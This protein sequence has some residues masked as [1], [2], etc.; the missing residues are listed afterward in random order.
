M[1][2]NKILIAIKNFSQRFD[3][4]DQKL[5]AMNNNLKSYENKLDKHM[6]LTEKKFTSI[7]GYV[8]EKFDSLKK[9]HE[10]NITGVPLLKD[11]RELNDFYTSLASCLGY[12][13]DEPN[14][15][16]EVKLFK[17]VTGDNMHRIIIRFANIFQKDQ[18]LHRYFAVSK[19]ITQK[20][21]GYKENKRIYI[22]QNLVTSKYKLFRLGLY[23][24][25]TGALKQVRIFDYGMIGIQFNDSPR[26]IMM[27]DEEQLK[28]LCSQKARSGKQNAGSGAV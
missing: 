5:N 18:F 17:I 10:L 11:D 25:R 8:D 14:K 21:L 16:P 6:E 3:S 4:I 13:P 24:K 20:K 27:E 26:F 9:A 15:S 12:S 22:Q 7:K 28:K 19:E 2:E 23:L 1:S